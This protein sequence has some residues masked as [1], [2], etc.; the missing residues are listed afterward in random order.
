MLDLD[1]DLIS[2]A[3]AWVEHGQAPGAIIATKF[4]D[5]DPA[6]GIAMQRPLC[7]YPT[8]A[9]YT[10]KGDTNDATNFSCAQP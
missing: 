10:G 9:T 7:P 5:D 3:V 8:V 4:V 1:H 6:K 2:A